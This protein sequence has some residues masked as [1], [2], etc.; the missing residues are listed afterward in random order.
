MPEPPAGL[1]YQAG[2]LSADEEQELLGRL[3][4]LD[5]ATIR[6]HGQEAKRTV[7]HF[8]VDYDYDAAAV[9]PGTPIPE[10]L[11]WLRGRCGD[12]AGIEPERLVEALVTRYPPGAGIGW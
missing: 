3:E 8:G 4:T 12:F 5:F 9:A 11:G 10:W 7:A 6:F 1:S 2:F